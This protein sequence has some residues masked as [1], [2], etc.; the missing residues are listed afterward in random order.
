MATESS[1]SDSRRRSATFMSIF[2]LFKGSISDH[3]RNASFAESTALRTSS[4]VPLAAVPTT[5]LVAGFL[6]SNVSP[7]SEFTNSP[8]MNNFNPVTQVQTR[9]SQIKCLV[10]WEKQG[11]GGLL[12][13]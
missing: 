5:S 4:R 6:T 1:S 13:L 7:L 2:P 10:R 8:S 11:L 12:R 9:K 3:V